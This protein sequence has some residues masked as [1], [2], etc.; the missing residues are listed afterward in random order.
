[1]AQSCGFDRWNLLEDSDTWCETLS[2]AIAQA[3]KF[4]LSDEAV[5]EM[6]AQLG[7]CVMQSLSPANQEQ[8]LLKD[9]WNVA[10]PEE[11]NVIAGLIFKLI[12]RMP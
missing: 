12:A 11:R 6:A 4:G 8:A 1:M 9:L 5:K 3:R 2:E 10:T 7:D